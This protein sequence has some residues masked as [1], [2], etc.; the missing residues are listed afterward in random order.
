[1]D[2]SST[3]EM[4]EASALAAQIFGDYGT[5]EN[6]RLI[7]AQKDRFDAALWSALGEAGLL[8]L[9]IPEEHGGAGLGILEIGAVLTE[10]GRALGAVPLASHV[11][12]SL[13]LA[14]FGGDASLL[15]QAATGEA[16]LTVAST[17]DRAGDAWIAVP[18]ATRAA[19]IVVVGDD[20]RLVKAADVSVEEQQV[21]T[22]EIL[23]LIRIAPAVLAAAPVLGD[24]AAVAWVQQRLTA[25]Q[26]AVQLGVTEGALTLTA[27]YARTR[28][29]FGRPI[30]TFQAV[31]QRLADGYID[32]LGLRM[33]LQQA[34]WRLSAGLPSAMEVSSA[35]VWAADAGHRVA[36][37][38][39]HVH[40]GVGIDLDGEAHRFFA[41]AKVNEFVIGGA[42][43]HALSIGRELATA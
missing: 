20:V 15:A 19:A 7:D 13:A 9:A 18:A 22:G 43:A 5:S 42:T 30:G 12:A 33:A 32:N 4:V 39:V 23:G 25:L 10:Q 14:E 11:A 16:I 41:N 1:M 3:P 8:G 29:Q 27:A 38:T 2:F 37:T 40:G 35:A 28:E 36:H 21:S 26:C 24:P 34:L 31:S 6:L 17:L